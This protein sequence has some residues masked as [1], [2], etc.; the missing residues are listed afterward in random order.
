[1]RQDPW[2][3]F[4]EESLPLPGSLELPWPAGVCGVITG[5]E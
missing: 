1:M 2:L 5:T 4:N 3:L